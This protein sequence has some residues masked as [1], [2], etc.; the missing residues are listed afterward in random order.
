MTLG[1][2]LPVVEDFIGTWAMLNS[3]NRSGGRRLPT[4][5][6]EVKLRVGPSGIEATVLG[7]GWASVASRGKWGRAFPTSCSDVWG[8]RA[9]CS[10]INGVE[11][12]EGGQS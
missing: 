3:S 4:S 5:A 10:S 9:G 11:L 6:S 2:S 8:A 1:G 7:W 12:R